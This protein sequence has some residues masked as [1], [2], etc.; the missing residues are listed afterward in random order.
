MLPKIVQGKFKSLWALMYINSHEGYFGRHQL[1]LR[2]AKITQLVLK[3]NE[4]STTTTNNNN[5]RKIVDKC[6]KQ[7][8][9]WETFKQLHRFTFYSWNNRVECYNSGENTLYDVFS[10]NQL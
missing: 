7:N 6:L 4:S 9:F 1:T 8:D 5:N 10:T 2:Q 3:D